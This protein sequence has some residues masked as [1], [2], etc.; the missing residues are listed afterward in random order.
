MAAS[1]RDG[2]AS[3]PAFDLE[4]TCLRAQDDAA[5][6]AE[7]LPDSP[8]TPDECDWT[9]MLADQVLQFSAIVAWLI[10]FE[11]ASPARRYFSGL[12]HVAFV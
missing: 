7:D 9:D 8:G 2:F 11:R 3:A 1:V 6:N 4:R 12:L 5:I 10:R